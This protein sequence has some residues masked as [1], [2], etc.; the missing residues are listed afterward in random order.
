[1]AFID[2]PY[3]LYAQEPTWVP[4]LRFERK[5]HL[6]PAKSP[7][8]AHAEVQ[9]FLAYRGDEV[10]GRISAH[11]D[12]ALDAHKGTE[13]GLWGFFES[14][15]RQETADALLAAVEAWHRARGRDRMVG[16]FDFST[17]HECG[18]LVEGH[19]RDP[20]IL[21]NWHFP[22]YQRLLEDAGMIKAMDSLM[23]EL[24]ID[25]RDKVHPAI[26][27][28][29]AKVESEHGIVCRGFRKK[30]LDSEV[31]KFLEVYN[32]AW[33]N[34]WASVPLSPDEIRS[35]A[36]DL[37]PI[38]D[39]NWAM[40]AEKK[41]TGEV[42]GAA[43]TLPDF[44]QALK[45][46]GNGKLLPFGWAKIL[47]QRKKIDKV[48]VFALGVKREYQHAGVAAKLYEMHFDAA[49]RTPQHG[50]EMGWILETNTAMNRAMEGMGGKVVRRYRF[51]E[52]LLRED[53]LPSR[54]EKARAREYVAPGAA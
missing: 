34:N 17:N 51:Y 19:D 52:K 50:G 20:I 2:F 13:W 3:R 39:E 49:A 54:D 45:A 6:D 35:Y 1:M 33:E 23:W 36:N 28:M 15:D 37:K 44:N 10:V 47:R 25:S 18:L 22:Y 32:E 11:I 38:L 9:L 12:H 53:A 29:A 26:W 4:A 46:T 31:D 14:E 42:V 7:F 30:D 8:F 16:P 40:I 43:L 41:D 24:Y 5:K 21:T 48:R 27:E